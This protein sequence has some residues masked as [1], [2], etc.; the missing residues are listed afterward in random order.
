MAI[1]YNE[2]TQIFTLQTAG[3]TYQ[4]MVAD[5]T[6]YSTF[7]MAGRW[8]AARWIICCGVRIPG[9][10]A[11]RMKREATEP[12]HWISSRRNILRPA[13]AITV[14]PVL[15]CESGRHRAADSVMFPMRLR[16]GL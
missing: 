7:I 9:S 12:F 14:P 3:S 15:R 13:W 6:F 1:T 5:T 11:T 2:A 4:M 10:Q 8:K 16:Q